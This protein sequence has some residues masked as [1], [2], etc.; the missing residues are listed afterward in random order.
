MLLLAGTPFAPCSIVRTNYFPFVCFSSTR[1]AP[2]ALGG[3]RPS[4]LSAILPSPQCLSPPSSAFLK[5][6]VDFDRVCGIHRTSS[7]HGFDREGSKYLRAT[8]FSE[9]HNDDGDMGSLSAIWPGEGTREREWKIWE[10]KRKKEQLTRRASS[11]M[12]SACVWFSYIREM[13]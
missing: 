13:R 8:T 6:K 10:R 7:S 1:M 9:S 4:P 12:M 5:P 3:R 2:L 11:R